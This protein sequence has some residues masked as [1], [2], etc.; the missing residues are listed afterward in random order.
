M[1]GFPDCT[2][3]GLARFTGAI[4]PDFAVQAG[5]A[6]CGARFT[7][8]LDTMTTTH[9]PQSTPTTPSSHFDAAARDWDQRPMSQQLAAVPPL[10]FFFKDT[11]TAGI[12][13]LIEAL[14][15][16]AARPIS[17]IAASLRSSQ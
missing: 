12:D 16:H 13:T 14:P 8:A 10:L 3:G 17:W 2:S 1:P 15:L 7:Q 4:V 5:H 11:A 9:P 6:R